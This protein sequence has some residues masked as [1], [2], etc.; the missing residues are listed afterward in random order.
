LTEDVNR[1]VRR[2]LRHRGATYRNS[3]DSQTYAR[4]AG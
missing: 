4:G 3:T 2:G 1:N